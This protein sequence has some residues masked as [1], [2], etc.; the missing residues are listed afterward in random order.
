MFFVFCIGSLPGND[1]GALLFSPGIR[2]ICRV[3]LCAARR[4]S[5]EPFLVHKIK[6]NAFQQ[7]N[8]INV[9]TLQ[10]GML[11]GN[12]RAQAL[13]IL[14]EMELLWPPR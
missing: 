7:V 2:E 14:L 1:K 12:T 8:N 9:D 5:E 13:C 10:Q 4:A 6:H 3:G 11:W